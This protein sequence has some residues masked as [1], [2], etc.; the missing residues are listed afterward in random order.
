M[1]K[2]EPSKEGT[3]N[4]KK[5]KK[6]AP[7]KAKPSEKSKEKKVK[8]AEETPWVT[9]EEKAQEL[10]EERPEQK[11][12]EAEPLRVKDLIMVLIAELSNKAWAYM[13][14]I[15][16]PETGQPKKDLVQAKLAIDT[17]ES[18]LE[19]VR[20][21]LNEGEIRSVESTLANLRINFVAMG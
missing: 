14:K 3:T 18:L 2:K 5:S 17:I 4:R 10:T 8:E 13:E 11:P 16:H 21:H 20:A 7:K 19:V 9:E 6:T 15:A 12:R 1:A